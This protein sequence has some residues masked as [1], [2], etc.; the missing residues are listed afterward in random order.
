MCLKNPEVILCEVKVLITQLCLTLCDPMDW[1]LP[2]SSLQGILQARILEWIAIP[3]FRGS[4]QPR[5]WTLVS[6]IAGKFFIIWAIREAKDIYLISLWE[7][8]YSHKE[9]YSLLFLVPHTSVVTGKKVKWF[10]FQT[11]HNIDSFVH[12]CYL[13]IE[14][15]SK[16]HDALLFSSVMYSSQW[17]LI[18][19]K[20]SSFSPQSTRI[21]SEE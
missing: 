21:K 16:R 15:T 8:R 12:S 7:L 19:Q 5:D 17:F 11:D 2:G 13:I 1:G 9:S 14:Q 18:I 4:S 20:K 3:F 10:W 6:H